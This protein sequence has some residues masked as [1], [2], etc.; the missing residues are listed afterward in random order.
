M[1][2]MKII[3]HFNIIILKNEHL[4]GD[5]SRFYNNCIYLQEVF[6]LTKWVVNK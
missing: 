5:L 3:F 1:I 4:H 2:N 6:D